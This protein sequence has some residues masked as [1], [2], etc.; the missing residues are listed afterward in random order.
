MRFVGAYLVP[1][2]DSDECIEIVEELVGD[3][4]SAEFVVFSIESGSALIVIST[5]EFSDLSVKGASSIS[6]PYAINSEVV[7]ETEWIDPPV[8]SLGREILKKIA[9]DITRDTSLESSLS[10]SSRLHFERAEK[11]EAIEKLP[12]KSLDALQAAKA[13]LA[14]SGTE[15]SLGESRT[16]RDKRREKTPAT[17]KVSRER[18]PSPLQKEGKPERDKQQ[19]DIRDSRKENLKKHQEN[20]QETSAILEEFL[21]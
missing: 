6:V 5:E 10:T 14:D 19:K 20:R 15:L 8:S 11:K 4:D 17:P 3:D 18:R 9:N 16:H 21:G 2:D 13:A 1:T 12:R 7:Y